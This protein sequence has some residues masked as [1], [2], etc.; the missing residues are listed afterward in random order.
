MTHQTMVCTRYTRTRLD[1]RVNARRRSTERATQRDATRE[2]RRVGKSVGKIYE[3]D[4]REYRVERALRRA[5]RLE[6]DER[7][8]RRGGKTREFRKNTRVFWCENEASRTRDEG[9]GDGDGGA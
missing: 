4:S 3:R 9:E 8:R 2:R 1:A 7:S 5:K 6:W